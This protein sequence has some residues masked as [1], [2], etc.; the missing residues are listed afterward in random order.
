MRQSLKVA[1]I[2][3]SICYPFLI[4]WGLQHYDAR[5]LLPLILILICLRWFAAPEGHGRKV[6]VG[7]LLGI[8]AVAVI[9][10]Q[11]MG[12]KFYPVMVNL[13]FLILFAGSLFYPPT[14]VE[15]LARIKTPELPA[16]AITY[17]RNVTW[18]WSLFFIT[19]GTIAAGTALWASD[20]VWMLYNGFISY[21]LIAALAGGEWVVRM[22]VM[23]G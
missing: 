20:E 10:G 7:V 17:T 5:V 23:R 6:A 18:V 8:V 9:W 16:E 15:K 4:Y 21:L 3:L 12:L 1:L 19:N 2:V 13:V 22:K 14:V 11:Q